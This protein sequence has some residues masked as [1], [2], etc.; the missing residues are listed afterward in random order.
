VIRRVK[1]SA[2]LDAKQKLRRGIEPSPQ[3]S[4]PYTD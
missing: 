3:V 4:V 1:K 2:R